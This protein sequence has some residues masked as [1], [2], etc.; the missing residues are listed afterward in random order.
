MELSQK[1]VPVITS[2]IIVLIG[3]ASSL[4]IQEEY[5][6]QMDIL[7]KIGVVDPWSF[8]SVDKETISVPEHLRQ[9]YESLHRQHRVRRAY[10][11]KGIHKNG[12]IH[13][14]VSYTDRTRQLFTFDVSHIPEGSEVIMAELKVYKERPNHS[15]FKPGP[16][17]HDVDADVEEILADEHNHEHNAFVSVQQVMSDDPRL[18]DS[19][20]TI[21]DQREIAMNSSGWKIF[22]VTNTIQTWVADP[23]ANHG[24][25]LHIDPLEG[26][27]HAEHVADSVVFATQ[28]HPSSPNS[29]PVLV[30][31]TTKFAPREEPNNCQ[32]E[33][34]EAERCCRRRKYVDFRDLTWTSRWII[35]PAGFEAFECMGHCP[36]SHHRFIRDIFRLPSFGNYPSSSSTAGTAG[37]PGSRHRTCGVSRSSSL[38]MMYLAET[39]SG[40]VELKVEE[41]PNMIVE[42]C[43][44]T[45]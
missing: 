34:E 32:Y 19:V 37:R 30:I 43:R 41:I 31:Y 40:T 44:C 28:F 21:V 2:A 16:D 15:I 33:G 24:I 27:H 10:I 18:G 36:N 13:G 12:E 7:D 1:S 17:D 26:A 4:P 42:D 39:E 29:S 35:E 14:Q 8:P 45:L 6:L 20:N 38:P 5:Y 22:D 23:E 3:L 11:T 25:E 9:R